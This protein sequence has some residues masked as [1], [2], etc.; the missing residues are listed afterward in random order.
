MSASAVWAAAVGVLL[1][2]ANLPVSHA[3][4]AAALPTSMQAV[5]CQQELKD[6][7]Y[8]AM[9][10][11]LETLPVPAPTGSQ[12]LLRV[13]GSSVNPCDVDIVKSDE[14][15]LARLLKKT[16]G[17]DVS[18]VV[19]AVGPDTDGRLK[20]GDEIWTDLGEMGFT[21]TAKIVQMG[22]LASARS[23]TVPTNDVKLLVYIRC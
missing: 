15:V 11:W 19:A 22:Q 4:A 14:D 9:D 16:L 1:G 10:K 23:V 3:T 20:V 17:F 6:K 13:V 2:A 7:N 8:T 18:G 5:V 21:P 12:V